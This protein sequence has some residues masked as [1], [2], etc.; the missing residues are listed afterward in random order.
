MTVPA[1]P[2]GLIAV[3]C[4]FDA[5]LSDEEYVYLRSIV[6]QMVPMGVIKQHILEHREEQVEELRKSAGT[7][8]H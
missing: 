2:M 1:D 4:E 5:L 7:V 3:L 6:N 8:V